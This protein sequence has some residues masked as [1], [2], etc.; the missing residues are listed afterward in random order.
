MGKLNL[1]SIPEHEVYENEF[2]ENIK[3]WQELLR[4][5]QPAI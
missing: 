1:A 5:K 3:N 2:S 4:Q